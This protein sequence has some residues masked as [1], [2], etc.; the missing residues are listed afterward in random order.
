MTDLPRTSQR[1]NKGVPP[2]RFEMEYED[3]L[4]SATGSTSTAGQQSQN[5]GP[6]PQALRGSEE[7]QSQQQQQSTQQQHSAQQQ[8]STQQQSAQPDILKVLNNMQREMMKQ[9]SL[10]QKLIA[11]QKDQTSASIVS[12]QNEIKLVGEKVSIGGQTSANVIGTEGQ[13]DRTTTDE[14]F[15]NNS[16][17]SQG[18]APY[19]AKMYPLPKFGGLPE[20]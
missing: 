12:L 5:T 7:R 14:S 16:S 20:E 8:Q 3:R 19:K 13:V 2:K 15:T 1:Q 6:P 17:H 18:P 10:V 11:S 4:T 9:I